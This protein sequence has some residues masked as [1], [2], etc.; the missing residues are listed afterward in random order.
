MRKTDVQKVNRILDAIHDCR[1]SVMHAIEMEVPVEHDW[2]V[3]R[4]K[5]LRAFGD[6][7]LTMRITEIINESSTAKLGGE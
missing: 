6:R 5:V 1:T 7:G 4:S 2:S 3:I